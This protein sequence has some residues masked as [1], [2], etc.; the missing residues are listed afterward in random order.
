MKE[1]EVERLPARN[2]QPT[3]KVKLDDGREIYVHSSYDPEQEAIHWAKG[4]NSGP[5]KSVVL[6]G[7]G[8]G[9]HLKALISELANDAKIFVIEPSDRIRECAESIDDVAVMLSLPNVWVAKDW[10]SFK[11]QFTTTASPWRDTISLRISAYKQIFRNEY[12]IFLSNFHNQINSVLVD[13]CTVLTSSQRWQE[14]FLRNLPYL[15]DSTPVAPAFGRFTGKPLIIVSAGPSLSLNIDSLASAQGKA[16]ILAVGTVNRLLASKGIIPDLVMSFDGMQGNYLHHF[17]DVQNEEIRLLYDPAI[18]HEVVSEYAGPK[19]L[20]LIHP[21]NQWIERQTG[22]EIGLLQIGPSIANTA[23][24]LA[25]K[26][27]ADP[28]IFVGQDLAYTNDA[29]HAVG[30]HV[31]GLRG[32]DYSLAEKAPPSEDQ[33]SLRKFVWVEGLNGEQVQTDSKMLTYLHWFEERIEDLEPTRTIIDATEGGAFINGTLPLS[34]KE[35]LA[36][37]CQEDISASIRRIKDLWDQEPGYD[38]AAFTGYLKTVRGCAK[39]LAN[40]CKKGARLSQNLKEHYIRNKPCDLASTL[41][42]LDRIDQ[43]LVR[44]EKNYIPLHYLTAP[45]LGVLSNQSSKSE[46]PVDLAHYSHLLYLELYRAFSRSLPLLGEVIEALDSG[47][48]NRQIMSGT[49]P[50]AGVQISQV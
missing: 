8:L 34:L 11:E 29:S 6:F 36:N 14:N 32:F 49:E 26:L 45:I 38:L 33:K 37:Y 42:R 15:S 50:T 27:G 24:D 13:L 4:V 22:T 21:G 35:T 12:Q 16:F 43:M 17:K 23:F 9:Y 18:Y 41:K 31:E 5:G 39:R 1:P 7:L 40:Q 28:I 3:L 30:T 46:N 25:C 10:T 48:K 44:E 2:G 19:S 20:M 47:T